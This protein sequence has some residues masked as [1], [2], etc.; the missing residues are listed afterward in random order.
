MSQF[1]DILGA[2]VEFVRSAERHSLPELDSLNSGGGGKETD[3]GETVLVAL[4]V[5]P[6][7]PGGEGPAGTDQA[8]TVPLCRWGKSHGSVELQ[9]RLNKLP[10]L[11]QAH[12]GLTDLVSRHPVLHTAPGLGP[13]L[14]Q[15]VSLQVL[16]PLLDLHLAELD[17][18]LPGAGPGDPGRLVREDE[19][20]GCDL[21]V[22]LSTKC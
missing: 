16:Q 5:Q 11:G 20:L 12:G 1:P 6:E 19:Y 2:V 22:C 15:A 7:T 13:T 21:H 14:H 3:G 4:L 9:D 8:Q 18:L 17:L 10:G